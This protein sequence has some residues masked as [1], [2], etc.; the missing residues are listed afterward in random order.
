MNRAPLAVFIIEDGGQTD[1][2]IGKAEK[3][4]S[5][6]V[7]AQLRAM[8]LLMTFIFAVISKLNIR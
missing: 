2:Q 5:S 4:I 8:T 6:I 3:L 1:I 7:T